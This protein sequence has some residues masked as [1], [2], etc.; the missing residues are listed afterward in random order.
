MPNTDESQSLSA[1]IMLCAGKDCA[2]KQFKPYERL[3]RA[4]NDADIAVTKI[5]C[6]GSCAGPTAVVVV[7]G[8]HRWFEKLQKRRDHDD[9]IALAARASGDPSKRLA[10][11][12]LTGKRRRKAER[13]GLRIAS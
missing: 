10:D 9:I 6:Q 3:R 8:E 11:R 2:R 5:G 1:T 7:D 12:E 4:A 13:K